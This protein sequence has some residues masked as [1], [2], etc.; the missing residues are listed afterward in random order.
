MNTSGFCILGARFKFVVKNSED[1]Y[2]GLVPAEGFKSLT[3]GS[4]VASVTLFTYPLFAVNL[5]CFGRIKSETKNQTLLYAF[6]TN[7]IY[8]YNFL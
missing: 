8:L 5:L 3:T 2:R 4:A 6:E 7:S 1:L